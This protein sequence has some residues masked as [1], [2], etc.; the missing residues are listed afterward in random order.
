MATNNIF[1][2]TIAKCRTTN[3]SGREIWSTHELENRDLLTIADVC[4]DWSYITEKY[5]DGYSVADIIF[6]RAGMDEPD[7]DEW[8]DRLY[9]A[10]DKLSESVTE[11]IELMIED[12]YFDHK[13][14]MPD[15]VIADDSIRY[16]ADDHEWVCDAEDSE[17]TYLLTAIDGNI[18]IV[19]CGSKR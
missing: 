8:D 1:D 5:S 16:D 15:L 12:W 17:N 18:Q 14:E 2:E 9:E 11:D 6:E 10:L 3:G 19:Y 13:D 4:P 7:A